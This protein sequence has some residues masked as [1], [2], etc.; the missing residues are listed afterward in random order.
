MIPK[1][2]HY[3]WFGGCPLSPLAQKCIASWKKNC[4][5]YEI[6]EWNESNY[7]ISS[8][9][10]YVRQAYES[11]KWG[12]VPDYIR[13]ELVYKYGGIYLDT[14]VEIIKSFD[15]LL[16]YEGF[17]G[18][19]GKRYIALGLGFGAKK[20]NETLKM[21]MNSY[22]NI[23]FLDENGNPDI[24]PAPQINTAVLN[25]LG[26]ISNGE[27]QTICDFTFLPTDYL[28][29]KS[30]DTGKTVLS[31][32]THSIHHYDGSWLSEEMV[33]IRELRYKLNNILPKKLAHWFSLM[34]GFTKFRGIKNMPSAMIQFKK[35]NLINKKRINIQ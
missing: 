31:D 24:T 3:C 22:L 20:G 19:E 23:P 6:I 9:P 28:C 35:Q 26:L 15:D 2:I 1:I 4:P 21:L 34:I 18:F 16:T 33:Y 27:L 5:D 29:P 32:N 7:D 12:F 11:K 13:L 25:K 10:L 17:A 30:P 14:D 8:A